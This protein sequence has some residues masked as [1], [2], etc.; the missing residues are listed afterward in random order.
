MRPLQTTGLLLAFFALAAAGSAQGPPPG[1]Y[2][3]VDTTTAASLRSTL[4]AVIDDHTRYPYT[5]GSTDTWDILGL[6][7]RDPAN[8]SRILDVYRN[9]SFVR[10]SGGNSFYNREHSWPTSYG[11]PSNGSG[12]M[13]FTDCH[14]LFLCDDGY[15]ASRSNKPFGNCTAGCGELTTDANGGVG[16][17]SGVFPGQS[18]WTFGAFTNGTFQVNVFRKGDI[19]RALL[20]ADVRYEG[21][22][23]GVTGVSEPDLILTDNTGQIAASN[24][25]QNESVAYMGRLA[26]LLDW[27]HADPVDAF[28]RTRND[29]VA[30]YQGNRNPFV[31]HPEWVDC[32]FV[33][34]CEPGAPYC[35]PAAANST[36]QAATIEG[37]GSAVIANDDFRL[38]AFQLPNQSAGYFL[39]SQTQGFILNPGGSSGN[40]CLAGNIG[41]VVGGQVVNSGF[42]G[43]F[44]VSVD[45]AALPQP[46][47]SVSAMAG[48]TW[49]FQAWY[50]DFVA[51]QVTSNFTDGWSVTWQ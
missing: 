17:G 35:S 27:H 41:R 12:N 21:G 3:T 1:Y 45:P 4:H 40:L 18:N 30:S 43:S 9:R 2:S 26:V 32:L 24:T 33:G 49:N 10:Q 14:M 13:P 34:A 42:F 37:R 50:R 7:Q 46:T 8:A 11:F 36:G 28:E 48:E 19:A 23:H 16:G 25:G 47:G 29:V 5:S 31:D 39:C 38:L 44:A 51:G 15:N 22:T 20:Y 6:A